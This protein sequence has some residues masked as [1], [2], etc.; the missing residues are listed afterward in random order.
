MS[1]YKPFYRRKLPHIQPAGATFF[2]TTMLEGAI[3]KKRIEKVREQFH[4]ALAQANLIKDSKEKNTRNFNLRK[5]YILQI[6]DLLHQKDKG[7]THLKSTKVANAL[8]DKFHQYD[9]ELY[10]LVAYTIMSNHFHL[11]I[12]TSIQ[13]EGRTLEEDTPDNYINLDK[14]MQRIKGGS[15]REINKILNTSGTFW[16]SESFDIVVRNEIMFKNVISYI[17]NNPVKAGLV[18]NYEDFEFNYVKVIK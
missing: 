14:I 6:D 18:D 9:K 15:A 12:D 1:S 16:E 3:S 11:L 17:L 13:L 5:A 2:I 7:P 4:L 10:S 8:K